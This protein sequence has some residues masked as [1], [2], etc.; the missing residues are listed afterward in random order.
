MLERQACITMPVHA[1][2]A[3]YLGPV[4]VLLSHDEYVKILLSENDVFF[5]LSPSLSL[6]PAPPLYSSAKPI[7]SRMSTKQVK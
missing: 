1:K 2:E 6:S 4:V 7:F 5:S 3:L